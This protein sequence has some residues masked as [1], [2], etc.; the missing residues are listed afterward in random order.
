MGSALSP[1]HE[2]SPLG[3]SDYRKEILI[4]RI[5]AGTDLLGPHWAMYT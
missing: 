5:K 3:V 2:L 1:P 4:K